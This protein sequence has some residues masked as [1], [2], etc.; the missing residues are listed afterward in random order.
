MRVGAPVFAVLLVLCASAVSPA[1]P[2]PGK[3]LVS[4]S[5]GMNPIAYALEGTTDA[6]TM[7][8]IEGGDLSP[9]GLQ[10]TYFHGVTAEDVEVWKANLDGSG[11]V[12]LTEAAGVGG[13]N[14][15]PRWSPDGG[16]IAFQHADPAAGQ[17]PCE[18]GFHVWVM[19]ADGSD[20]HR[21]TP[22]A[23]TPTRVPQWA[24]DGARLLCE[25]DGIGALIMDLDGANMVVLPGV[26]GTPAW[27]PDGAWIA[28]STAE[29]DATA[30][31]MWRSLVLCKSD[32]SEE[33]VLAARFISNSD[34]L[35]HLA[36]A[37][38]DATDFEIAALQ[39]NVGPVSPEWS[40]TGDLIAFVAVMPLVIDGPKY[41]LQREVWVH[42]LADGTNTQITE[43]AWGDAGLSWRGNNTYPNY[44]TVTVD[45]ASVTFDEVSA[46]GLTTILLEEEPPALPATYQSTGGAFRIATTAAFAGPATMAMAFAEGAV[47]AAAAGHLELLRY[48]EGTEQWEGI[49]VSR[50]LAN[51]VIRGETETLGLVRLAWPLPASDFS[52]VSGSATDPFWALW[53]IEAASAAGIVQGYSDGTYQPGRTVTRDQMAVYISRALAG[54]DGSVQV[55]SGVAEPTFSDVGADHWAYRYI[56]YC[57]GNDLVQGYT[58]GS[59]HPDE[60]VNRGQMAVYIA[61]AVA[62][63]DDAVPADTDGPTFTDVTGAN[64]W[65]WC[66]D[67]VEY[68]AAAGI[69]QGYSDST[70]H[71]ENPVTRDQMAVYVARAFGLDV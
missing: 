31:G 5:D 53:E 3:L 65:A 50:D 60:A 6:V 38:L 37:G 59:Y 22:P 55:P 34:V 42:N 23:M 19:D 56:E 14:C 52:D 51:H 61:R 10:A 9:D 13:V 21:V 12:N 30:G 58:D 8:P 66:Y 32:G 1:M 24:G 36:S 25:A 27:S 29:Y 68:C 57:A 33:Q 64:D 35:A 67:Y 70:Y 49:T 7:L 40:P 46:P 16:R 71:P 45:G 39:W 63:G 62:G 18:A 20:A 47:P 41:D 2:I 4:G 48:D 26:G 17:L 69:V 11:A 15:A 44:P 43:N 28:S 54:G